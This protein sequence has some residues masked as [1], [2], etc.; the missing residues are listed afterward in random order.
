MPDIDMLAREAYAAY[1]E[2][3]GNKNYRGEEMPAYD[4]L[5]E[6]IQDA[7]HSAVIRVLSLTRD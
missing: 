2:S 6:N 3:T 4:D 7:W 5:G 1:G